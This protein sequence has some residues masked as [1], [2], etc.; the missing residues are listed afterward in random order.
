TW[1][2]GNPVDVIGDADATR[3]EAALDALL[4]GDDADAVLV[5]NCPTALASSTEIAERIGAVVERQ[6][7]ASRAAKAVITNWLGEE[8]SRGARALFA[9][10]GFGSFATPA[11]AVDG[12]MYLVRHARAQ[13]ELMRTP[14]SLPR[15]FKVDQQR[16][17]ATIWK[18][19]AAGR[20]LL[21]EPE[22]K[23]LLLSYGIATAP[24]LI[25]HNPK[26]VEALAS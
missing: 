13:D 18:A 4:A 7:S 21:S 12:F 23:E 11:E 26:E 5:I 2:Q 24:S 15:D 1:S 20:P 19:I 25:A 8:A 22:G 10:K 14:P 6:R 3:Y 9:G 16:A 17:K